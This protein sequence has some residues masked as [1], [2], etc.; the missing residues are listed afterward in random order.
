MITCKIL[1][2]SVASCQQIFTLILLD[3][4]FTEPVLQTLLADV[5]DLSDILRHNASGT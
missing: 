1:P 5:Q 2:S 4:T 3:S